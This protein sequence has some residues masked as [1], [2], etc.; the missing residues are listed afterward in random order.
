MVGVWMAEHAATANIKY[1]G[2]FLYTFY[3]ISFF[4]SLFSR[5]LLLLLQAI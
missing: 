2:E 4:G 5:A 3:F 1:A